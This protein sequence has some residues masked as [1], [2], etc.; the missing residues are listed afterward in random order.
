M[1]QIIVD[2]EQ[3]KLIAE[4]PGSI[5]IRDRKGDLLGYAK[6]TYK[7]T[8]E[9]IAIAKQRLNSD[10]PRYTT[11]EVFEHLKSLGQ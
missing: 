10:E 4:S 6:A 3:A 7:W 2:D 1:P 8:E 11:K 9:D 5:E